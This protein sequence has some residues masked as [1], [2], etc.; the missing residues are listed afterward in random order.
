MRIRSIRRLPAAVAVAAAV[1][2]TL[3]WA[4]AASAQSPDPTPSTSTAPAPR[5]AAETGGVAILKKDPAGEV[6]AGATFTL[7]DSAGKEVGSGKT[8]ADGQLAFKDLAPG[9]YRLKEVSSGSKL[10][11]TVDDQD[12]IVTP[13]AAAPMTII[14]P[15]KPAS[16]RLTAKDD[17]SGKLLAGSTV[18]IGSG[19][20]TVLTLTTGSNGSATAQL[21]VNSPTGTDF[22]VKQVKAPDGYD[23]Y[24][25][26]KTFTAKPG[27]P[28][29]VTVSNAKTSSTTPPATPTEKPT[30][31]PTDKPASDKL[32]GDEST[33]SPSTSPSDTPAADQTTS[34]TAAPAPQGTLAHTG[35]DAT[36]WLLAGAGLLLAIGAGAV[37]VARRRRTDDGSTE[38]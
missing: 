3:S 26:S 21:P 15:F 14:D 35:A 23:L 13:G 36:P 24:K 27:D 7:L 16:L 38:N 25:P 9:V 2:G 8:N 22:W 37:I 31:K 34:S 29:T 1:T 20:K 30:E 28:V 32:H 4:P 19:D 6:L 11:D 33:S 17:T 18:D 10:L 12:V 5:I